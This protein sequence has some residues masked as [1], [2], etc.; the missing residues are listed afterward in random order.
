VGVPLVPG[1]PMAALTE[2]RLA[3][4]DHRLAAAITALVGLRIDRQV[5]QAE[6]QRQAMPSELPLYQRLLLRWHCPVA[7]EVDNWSLDFR[8]LTNPEL[9]HVAAG[10]AVLP[11]GSRQP[12]LFDGREAA[13]AGLAQTAGMASHGGLPV[14]V[15]A[16]ALGLALCGFLAWVLGARRAGRDQAD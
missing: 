12:L 6:V 9:G 4:V 13:R 3:A 14:P 5:C 10:K 1:E 7:A 8:L 11:D 2:Q 15:S 16:S